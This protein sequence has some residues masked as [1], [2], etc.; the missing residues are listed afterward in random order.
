[1]IDLNKQH[2]ITVI[3]N[4]HLP[5][6]NPFNMLRYAHLVVHKDGCSVW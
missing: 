3:N 2:I 6:T 5:Q 4:C 1:L